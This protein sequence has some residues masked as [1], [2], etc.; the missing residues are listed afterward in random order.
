MQLATGDT[1]CYHPVSVHIFF[2][3]FF[4]SS[5][6]VNY[7]ERELAF[8]VKLLIIKSYCGE[9]ESMLKEEKERK[10][11]GRWWLVVGRLS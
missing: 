6:L 10:G 3:L 1:G 2:L 4:F 7:F 11:L 9:K 8:W 5:P